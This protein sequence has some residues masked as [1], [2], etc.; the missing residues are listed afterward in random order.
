MKAKTIKE[1]ANEY[2]VSRDT[3]VAWL[4]DADL[5]RLRVGKLFPPV[6]IYIIYSKFG[7]PKEYAS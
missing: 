3:F 7:N 5:M 4:K 6:T 2:G 1:L